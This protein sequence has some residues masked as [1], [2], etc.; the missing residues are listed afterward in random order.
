MDGSG[1]GFNLEDHVGEG[2]GAHVEVGQNAFAASSQQYGRHRV[3]H[4][5]QDTGH[6]GIDGGRA[7]AAFLDGIAD[8]AR[9]HGCVLVPLHG[10]QYRAANLGNGLALVIGL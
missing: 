1:R 3:A 7:T 2:V 10:I 9:N 6:D 8:V 5:V 4:A